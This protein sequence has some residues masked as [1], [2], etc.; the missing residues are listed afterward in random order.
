[1][2]RI[3]QEW[4][5]QRKERRGQ[6]AT[7]R[8]K[9]I[10][11]RNSQQTVSIRYTKNRLLE[12]NWCPHTPKRCC[13]LPQEDAE[14]QFAANKGLLQRGK[15]RNVG[16]WSVQS[17]V[18]VS[19]TACF[20]LHCEGIFKIWLS[21]QFL[22]F[23]FFQSWVTKKIF[24]F[25]PDSIKVFNLWLPLHRQI[26]LEKLDCKTSTRNQK[27][28]LIIS[29]QS[30]ISVFIGTITWSAVP[31]AVIYYVILVDRPFQIKNN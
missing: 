21:P 31:V 14:Q 25:P 28:C 26:G 12:I 1:M 10:S 22:H 5:K 19:V 11:N 2:G 9:N 8:K 17:E 29:Q 30:C 6:K 4:R 27:Q 13:F 15:L 20:M 24:Y 16:V 23:F 7:E 3:G 18:S